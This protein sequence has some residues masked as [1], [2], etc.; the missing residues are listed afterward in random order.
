[1]AIFN[2]NLQTDYHSLFDEEPIKE[3]IMVDD[4][5][6]DEF[7]GFTIIDENEAY[8]RKLMAAAAEEAEPETIATPVPENEQTVLVDNAKF[9]LLQKGQ[10]LSLVLSGDSGS[11]YNG[12]T[13]AADLKPAYVKKLTAERG[14]QYVYVTLHEKNPPMVRLQFSQTPQNGYTKM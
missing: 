10:P 7:E 8:R 6:D 4:S 2:F 3:N 9:A 11:V 13:K 5:D 14:G 1:M 12:E